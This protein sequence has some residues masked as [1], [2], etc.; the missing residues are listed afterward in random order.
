[1]RDYLMQKM[2]QKDDLWENKMEKVSDEGTSRQI[3]CKMVRE[4]MLVGSPAYMAP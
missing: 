3:H 4:R 2:I 1:M